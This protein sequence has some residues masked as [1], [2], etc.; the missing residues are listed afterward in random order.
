MLANS[1]HPISNS[2]VLR[3]ALHPGASAARSTRSNTHTPTPTAHKAQK[4]TA[5]KTKTSK[6]SIAKKAHPM[7]PAGIVAAAKAKV[8]PKNSVG[9]PGIKGKK[10]GL[11]KRAFYVE[12]L[13][14]ARKNRTTD[15]MIQKMWE[16]EFPKSAS[17]KV[18]AIRAR[19]NRGEFAGYP[20][21]EGIVT[22]EAYTAK[23]LATKKAA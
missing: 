4:G 13:L 22:A 17:Y 11:S 15:E 10:S 19:L 9:N 18:A 1:F 7:S 20:V 16:A 6:K 2:R 8:A 5:M 23:V 12:T 21:H 3:S 14:N